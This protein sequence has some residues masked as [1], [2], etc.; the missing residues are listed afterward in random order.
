MR[1]TVIGAGITGLTFG[2]AMRQV[3]P[4]V[5][6]VLYERDTSPTSR[7]QGYAIGIKGD[8]G[9]PVLAKLG[10]RDKMLEHR[11]VRITGFVFTDQHG[12][13]LL[14]LGTTNADDRHTT[15][16][17]QRTQ[18]KD[19][20]RDSL[21]GM[22]IEFSK[23]CLAVEQTTNDVTAV[24]EDGT[25]TTADFLVACDGVASA[26][27]QQLIGDS[28]NYLGLTSIYGDVAGAVDNPLLAGGYFMSLGANG[29]SFFAYGQPTGVHWSYT[30][31]SPEGVLEAESPVD[32]LQRVRTDTTSW[33]ELVTALVAATDARTIG[34]RAYYDKEP[35]AKVR[36]G[37]VWLLGD[38]A[39]PMCPFQGQGA[40]LG[41]LDALELAELFGS[42]AIADER[43]SATLEHAIVR[44]GRK[45]VL[46]SRNAAKQFHETSPLLRFNR[47][48][49][50]RLGDFFIH[51]FSHPAP[52]RTEE[53]VE[54]FLSRER[55]N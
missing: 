6:T 9:L 42:Q 12:V 54:P 49:G 51:L 34:I 1:V 26:V 24:F 30:F 15:Y 47:D 13:E 17:I 21:D 37:R 38:A 16:R 48:L 8:G 10:I 46:D 33:H 53:T 41:M 31:H 40:N 2:V 14:R 28:K 25:C 4:D 5:A 44:R 29:T 3:A 45:A 11:S 36:Y 23:H 52:A 35:I 55:P 39:H 27:R 20:L 22:P 7:A 19:V 50:M 43:E 32:L 18:I